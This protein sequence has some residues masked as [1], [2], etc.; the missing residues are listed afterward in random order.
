MDEL[1]APYSK[2]RHQGKKH[3]CQPRLKG[4]QR[5]L[6]SEDGQHIE[7][8]IYLCGFCFCFCFERV[9]KNSDVKKADY[10]GLSE[11]I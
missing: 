4:T 6:T 2:E 11:S 8:N 1:Q 7:Q 3:R 5:L 9:L 10:L